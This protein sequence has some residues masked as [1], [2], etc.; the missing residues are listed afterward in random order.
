VGPRSGGTGSAPADGD[1]PPRADAFRAAW[2]SALDALELD[3]E[4]AEALLRSAAGAPADGPDEPAPAP[5]GWTVPVVHGP[6]PDDLAARA[7][8]VLER[9]LRAGEELARAMSGNRRHAALAAR[10]DSGG[11]R[12]RPVFLDRAL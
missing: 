4:H 10:L 12:E 11:R 2:V 9:Q 5:G 7:A 6:L 1:V 8:A 3:V